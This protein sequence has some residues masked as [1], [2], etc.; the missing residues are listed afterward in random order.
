M[1]TRKEFSYLRIH[2]P[3][4]AVLSACPRFP[5]NQ[6]LAYIAVCKYPKIFGVTYELSS[7]AGVISSVSEL[8]L[9]LLL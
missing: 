1:R 3:L 2:S 9:L 7:M 5:P 6:N 4:S 8:G